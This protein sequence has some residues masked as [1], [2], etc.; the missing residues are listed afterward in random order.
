MIMESRIAF[1]FYATV[2]NLGGEVAD[3]TIHG[4]RLV[5]KG[6]GYVRQCLATVGDLK[7]L[8]CKKAERMPCDM[9]ESD[10]RPPRESDSLLR[11]SDYKKRLTCENK[12]VYDAVPRDVYDSQFDSEGYSVRRLHDPVCGGAHVP[13][14]VINVVKIYGINGD[15]TSPEILPDDAL[16][17]DVGFDLHVIF[18]KNFPA[19]MEEIHEKI[20]DE[21]KIVDDVCSSLVEKHNDSI[22]SFRFEEW[23][24]QD[25]SISCV[26]GLRYKFAFEENLQ[27]RVELVPTSYK[28]QNDGDAHAVIDL[29]FVKEHTRVKFVRVLKDGHHR[30]EECMT[31][32]EYFVNEEDSMMCEFV[33][34]GVWKQNGNYWKV[35]EIGTFRLDSNKVPE[36][37]QFERAV[38]YMSNSAFKQVMKSLLLQLLHNKEFS[39]SESSSVGRTL[40]ELKDFM[41]RNL[42]R[43]DL[44]DLEEFFLTGFMKIIF[45]HTNIISTAPNNHYSIECWQHLM[46]FAIQVLRPRYSKAELDSVIFDKLR[47][48]GTSRGLYHVFPGPILPASRLVFD[49]RYPERYDD[50]DYHVLIPARQVS[51]H[52]LCWFSQKHYRTCE[53]DFLRYTKKKTIAHTGSVS[54]HTLKLVDQDQLFFL[55]VLERYYLMFISGDPKICRILEDIPRFW[56]VECVKQFERNVIRWIGNHVIRRI[57][58]VIR[59]TYDDPVFHFCSRGIVLQEPGEEPGVT[60]MGLLGVAVPEGSERERLSARGA[61]RPKNESIEVRTLGPKHENVEKW[62]SDDTFQIKMELNYRILFFRALEGEV[63]LEESGR[64]KT[65]DEELS[66]EGIS[67]V[68][69]VSAQLCKAGLPL[70]DISTKSSSRLP[71]QDSRARYE[72]ALSQR[73]L[74]NKAMYKNIYR[75]STA[76]YKYHDAKTIVGGQFVSYSGKRLSHIK[77]SLSDGSAGENR[78]CSIGGQE[79]P[80]TIAIQMP[81]TEQKTR[82]ETR[83][84]KVAVFEEMTVFDD[85][86]TMYTDVQDNVVDDSCSESS[87]SG[88]DPLSNDSRSSG[89]KADKLQDF[90]QFTGFRNGRRNSYKLELKCEKMSYG[91]LDV[92]MRSE[93]IQMS[94]RGYSRP[95]VLDYSLHYA[96]PKLP[97]EDEEVKEMRRILN[98]AKKFDHRRA[99]Y[100]EILKIQKWLMVDREHYAKRFFHTR[101]VDDDSPSWF[102]VY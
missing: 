38:F 23:T 73:D 96:L 19:P 41:Q 20:R 66:K 48:I 33:T 93:T 54:K 57:E 26:Q 64:I 70:K 17:E 74:E 89:G 75:S 99:D 1:P 36:I 18:N 60:G 4:F 10:C 25:L 7:E 13:S 52:F 44:V 83:V 71:Q 27:G 90:I 63:V 65:P 79:I 56:K 43:Y 15:T 81:V 77:Y 97:S 8:Y 42:R 30:T 100:A 22:D 29:A 51:E 28:K 87:D 88:W 69:I 86:N 35:T 9:F 49:D 94:M 39:G 82:D 59:G 95:S 102:S 101:T 12:N 50:P 78:L 45:L 6:M 58:T 14:S 3:F 67:E 53:R 32:D 2:T 16:L 46:K 76:S 5:Q 68:S 21:R 11:E 34:D 91:L 62:E 37:A 40:N 55:E 85:A 80:T 24:G 72:S 98:E 31:I 92:D 47:N 84:E 61:I